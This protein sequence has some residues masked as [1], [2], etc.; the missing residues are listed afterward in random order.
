MHPRVRRQHKSRALSGA[1]EH[2]FR[3]QWQP[4][5]LLGSFDSRFREQIFTFGM[6]NSSLWGRKE[7][8]TVFV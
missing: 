4:L 2:V 6:D 3:H 1:L 5:C 7:K 8:T